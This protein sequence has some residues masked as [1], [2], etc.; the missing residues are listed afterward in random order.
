MRH[1]ILLLIMSMASFVM[2]GPNDHQDKPKE[3]HDEQRQQT[4]PGTGGGESEGCGVEPNDLANVANGDSSNLAPVIT[5][6]TAPG[7]INARQAI[8]RAAVSKG[9][10]FNQMPFRLDELVKTYSLG[11]IQSAKKLDERL[12]RMVPQ[13]MEDHPFSV[14]EQIPLVAQFSLLSQNTGVWALGNI[15]K[16]ELVANASQ[17]GVKDKK[18][19]TSEELAKNLLQM[20]VTE[21]LVMNEVVGMVEDMALLSQADAL[22][23]VLRGLAGAASVE[24]ALVPVFNAAANAFQR[25]VEKGKKGYTTDQTR[26]LTS[27]GLE[28][29]KEAIQGNSL[30]N[31]G[32]GDLNEAFRALLEGKT[33][34]A[35]NLKALWKDIVRA[36]AITPLLPNLAE[37]IAASFTPQVAFLQERERKLILL[38]SRNYP[39][40]AFSIEKNLLLAWTQTWDDLHAGRLS[41]DDFNQR[42]EKF[43]KPLVNELLENDSV[44][45]DDAWLYAAL[46][47]GLVRDEVVE[48][49]FPAFVLNLLE[50][51]EKA[52]SHLGEEPTVEQAVSTF[53]ENMSVLWSLSNVYIP[54]LKK[55][56]LRYDE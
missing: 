25:G 51:R 3:P 45:L 42:R 48:K 27:A 52:L 35:L 33:I 8:A 30:L 49:R 37:M 20:G 2:A 55:W 44:A 15:I 43:F 38:A 11:S 19:G 46:R 6:L 14:Q 26:N 7:C 10:Q 31:P 17:L 24:G 40:L 18:S 23:K 47:R 32:I 21:N 53:A 13:I 34:D 4:R 39:S 36:L 12:R 16:E 56:V 5:Y 54:A 28:G 22:G 50:R 1:L 9:V 41:T 29:A